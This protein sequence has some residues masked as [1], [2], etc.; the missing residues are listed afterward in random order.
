MDNIIT[1]S[2]TLLV[3][4]A[5]EY[6][7]FIEELEILKQ[8]PTVKAVLIVMRSNEQIRASIL[9]FKTAMGIIGSLEYAKTILIKDFE[10]NAREE[11]V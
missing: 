10:E 6:A 9:G 7:D 8:D 4:R 5:V 3:R 11:G 2:Q 1:E